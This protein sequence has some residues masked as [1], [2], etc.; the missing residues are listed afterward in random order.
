VTDG[1]TAT[2]RAAEAMAKVRYTEYCAEMGHTPCWDEESEAYRAARVE[3]MRPYLEAALPPFRQAIADIYAAESK[4]RGAK[5]DYSNLGYQE[6]Y[7][8]ALDF[9]ERV[10]EASE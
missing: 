7:L 9:A 6:G 3:E 10:A 8:D 2:E 5:K 1:R 4:I